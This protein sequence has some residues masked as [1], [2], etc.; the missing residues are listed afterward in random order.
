MASA[1]C[2]EE[3]EGDRASELEQL[4]EELSRRELK[5]V[6]ASGQ[7]GIPV[8]DAI[9]PVPTGVWLTVAAKCITWRSGAFWMD[10]EVL[11]ADIRRAAESISAALQWPRQALGLTPHPP[12]GPGST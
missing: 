11:S 6:L 3:P 2:R 12:G 7:D 5:T 1:V 9:R 8:L 10:G 4:G